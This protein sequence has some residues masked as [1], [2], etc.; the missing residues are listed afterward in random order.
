MLLLLGEID[1]Q[2][3]D[4]ATAVDLKHHGAALLAFV[5]ILVARF[6]QLS[7]F[8]NYLSSSGLRDLVELTAVA[9]LSLLAFGSFHDV[10]ADPSIFYLF[11]IV[12]A[13]YA[14][15]QRISKFDYEERLAYY[16]DQ[17][18]CDSSV[19]DVTIRA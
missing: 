18:S 5:L 14:A 2:E 11:F 1:R 10:L 3:E 9:V 12:F 19:I 16:G 17:R 8:S 7:V 13:V 15:A 6:R 4:F